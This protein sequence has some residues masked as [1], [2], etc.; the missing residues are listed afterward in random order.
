MALSC[1]VCGHRSPPPKLQ[2]GNIEILACPSCGLRFW[3]PRSDFQPEKLYDEAYFSNSEASVGYD[4]YASLEASLRSTFARR[5]GRIP[6]PG[7]GARM[8]DVGAAFGFAADEARRV[9]WQV[10]ALEVSHSAASQAAS[11]IGNRVVVADALTLPFRDGSFHAVT[12]WDVLEHLRD[13]HAAVAEVARVLNPGGRFL[14]STA[15]VGSV[16]ARLS[17]SRWHLYTLPEHLFFHTR[18][19]LRLLLET[20]RFRIADMRAESSIYTLAYLVERVRKSLFG[21]PAK[22]PAGW[23]GRSLRIPCNLFD[24]VTVDALKLP[25]AASRAG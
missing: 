20:H 13:P 1:A 19:S 25:E 2:K 17:R 6:R 18:K 16:V 10:A 15:D 14:L 4:A 11:R 12:M 9:G 24:I 21:R 23:P 8:L 7:A 5:I 3:V 22:K